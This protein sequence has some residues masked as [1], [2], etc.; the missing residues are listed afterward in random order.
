M[1]KH[2]ATYDQSGEEGKDVMTSG[3]DFERV[4]QALLLQGEPDRVPLAE[5]VIDQAIKDAFLGYPVRDVESEVSFWTRAGYDY[6]PVKVGSHT[7]DD[8][9]RKRKRV[10]GDEDYEKRE[11]QEEVRGPI[12]TFEELESFPWPTD[13]EVGCVDDVTGVS[14]D[15][16][17]KYLPRGVKV[18][19]MVSK[20]FQAVWELMGFQTF[21]FA[22][23]DNPALV[24]QLFEKVGSAR[25]GTFERMSG[26]SCVGAMWVV[27]D[28]AYS[29]GLMISPEDLRRYLFPWYHRMGEIC[30]E[31]GLPFI[32]HSDGA[33][34]E[35]LDDIIASGFNALHPVEPKAMDIVHLKEAA[36]NRL[37]LI[38]NIGLDYPLTR[39]TPGD[40]E[41]AV[42]ERLR[43]VA[44][45]GGYCLGSSNSVTHYVP[46]ENFNAMRETALRYG[47]YP[48]SI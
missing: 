18:I 45:G 26:Y 29:N 33:L 22:L 38:G 9:R 17:D 19:G 2:G 44:P 48:I 11:W 21:C 27:D 31:K 15:D 7:F 12:I 41:G 35:A 39:G 23:V 32:F 34:H 13:E 20:I 1:T 16:L 42:K 14:L 30:K 37:C 8:P 4:K 10:F 36:G 25:L 46:L 5:V 3:P 24:K 28:I 47:T 40:V 6:V 43:Q